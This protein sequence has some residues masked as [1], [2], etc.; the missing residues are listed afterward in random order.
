MAEENRGAVYRNGISVAINGFSDSNLDLNNN[1]MYLTWS[2][3]NAYFVKKRFFSRSSVHEVKNIIT[4][5]II[6]I[7]KANLIN[8]TN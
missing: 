7:F 5:G 3:I 6:Y 4:N 8:K 2:N 1:P